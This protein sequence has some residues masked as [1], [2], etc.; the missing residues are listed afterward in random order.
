MIGSA[1]RWS[2]EHDMMVRRFGTGPELVWIHGLGEWSAS[3]DPVAAHPALAGFTH[4]LPDL[5]GYGRSPWPARPDDL[6]AVADRLAAWLGDRKPVVLGHSMGGVLAHY[7]AERIAVRAVID[8]DGNLSRGDCTFSALA[9]A[10]SLDDFVGFG[11]SAIRADAYER[12]R[13]DLALRGYHAAMCAAAPHVFHHHAHQLIELSVAE[14]RPAGL[15]A[16]RVPVLFVAG[17]PDGICPRS[18]ELLDRHGVRWVGV[19]PAGH[20][21]WIDQPAGFVAAVAD[22]LG[23]LA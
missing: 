7:V 11:F 16:L 10:Y 19:E 13:T 6:A 8:V 18:R 3:F 22:L 15:A 2:L 4:V 21:V 20:W 17:V 5:P 12:G 9:A 14:A 23:A 1:M